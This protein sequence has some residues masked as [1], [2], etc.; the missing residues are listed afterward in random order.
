[1]KQVAGATHAAR[2]GRRAL[3]VSRILS[4]TWVLLLPVVG[5]KRATAPDAN[6]DGPLLYCSVDETFARDILS[7]YEAST[8]RKVRV[9]FDSEAGKT[10]GLVRRIQAEAGKTGADVFWSSEIFNTILLARQGRLAP[11]DSPAA[12]GIPAQYKDAENRW[13]AFGLRARVVAFD[14]AKIDEAG[15]PKTWEAYAQP[16]LATKLAIA[17][18]VFG[19][20]RGHVAA[21]FAGW[22]AERATAFLNALAEHALVVDGN[23]TAVRMII[24]GRADLCFTDIDDVVVAQSA[25][26]SLRCI[27]PDMGDGGTLMIPNSVA[28]IAGGAHTE[29]AKKLIDYLVSAEVEKL[30]ALSESRNLPVRAELREELDLPMIPASPLS[31]DAIADGMESAIDTARKILVE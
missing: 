3:H 13:T 31:Y 6:R 23:S 24:A 12:A 5:C 14:S 10:T 11:Y 16:E 4:L 30:L 25:R 1:M 29:E 8:G 9:I 22:G 28:L 21:M 20:T 27:Y 26:P 19:T 17:N 2:R 18:P 15:L 7:R